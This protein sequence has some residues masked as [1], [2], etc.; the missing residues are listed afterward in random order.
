[1]ADMEGSTA[2]TPLERILARLDGVRASGQGFLARCPA[3]DD[4]H[5]SLSI[6]EGRNGRVLLHCWA[7]CET[8]E[9]IAVSMT[10]QSCRSVTTQ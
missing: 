3:H 6:R 10:T 2:S 4:H 7:G 8:A 9:V 1:M 5:P